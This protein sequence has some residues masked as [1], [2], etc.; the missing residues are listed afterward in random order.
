MYVVYLAAYCSFK[1]PFP[2]TVIFFYFQPCANKHMYLTNKLEYKDDKKDIQIPWVLK[3]ET[4][5]S[6]LTLNGYGH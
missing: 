3:N 1:F 2:K 5:P 4:I 6:F